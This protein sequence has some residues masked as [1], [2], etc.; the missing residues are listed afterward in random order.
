MPVAAEVMAPVSEWRTAPPLCPP[1]EVV[2]STQELDTGLEEELHMKKTRR[3]RWEQRWV[4]ATLAV[5]LLSQR[6]CLLPA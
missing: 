4:L 5:T 6:K 1:A 2:I 3:G